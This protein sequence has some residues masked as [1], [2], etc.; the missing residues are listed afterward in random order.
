MTNIAVIANIFGVYK[1]DTAKLSDNIKFYTDDKM[2]F[3]SAIYTFDSIPVE[4]IEYLF[5]KN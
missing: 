3:D 2:P 5:E 1:I 4:A